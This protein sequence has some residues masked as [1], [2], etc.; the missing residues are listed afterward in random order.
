D[1]RPQELGRLLDLERPNHRPALRWNP[2]E[3]RLRLALVLHEDEPDA[4]R[5]QHLRRIAADRRAVLFEDALLAL[6]LLDRTPKPVADVSMLG[7]DAQR[8]LL[9]AAADEDLRASSL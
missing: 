3:Q 5:Q 7:E 2:V 9:A 8:A 4:N 1:V 6:E